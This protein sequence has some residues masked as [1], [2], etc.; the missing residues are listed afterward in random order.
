MISNY[1]IFRLKNLAESEDAFSEIWI[2]FIRY[3]EQHEI[4]LNTVRNFLLTMARNHLRDI[5]RKKKLISAFTWDESKENP[6]KMA[7]RDFRDQLD[8][9]QMCDYCWKKAG[10]LPD[11]Q[12]EAFYL[13]FH[14]HVSF[15]EIAKIQE[16]TLNTA[17][18][19]V[20]Y[21]LTSLKASLE[22][23]GYFLND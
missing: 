8:Q 11:V 14:E 6:P 1:L 15:K 3:A 9:K 2:K 19:R 16:S 4:E 20:R 18:S 22:K 12:K 21:A 10:E 7:T 17:L 23:K 5:F 13:R